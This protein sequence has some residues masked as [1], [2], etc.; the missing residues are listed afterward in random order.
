MKEEIIL[1]RYVV[2][3]LVTLVS[4]VESLSPILVLISFLIL[5]IFIVIDVLIF[6]SQ[7]ESSL[8]IFCLRIIYMLMIS[9]NMVKITSKKIAGN[10]KNDMLSKELNDIKLNIF[11]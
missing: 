8:E 11:R 10:V 1:D 7:A 3:S 4:C 2:S 9:M 5:I 6:I